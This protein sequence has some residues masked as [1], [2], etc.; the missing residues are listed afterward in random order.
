MRLHYVLIAQFEAVSTASLRGAA[1]FALVE[2]FLREVPN[3]RVR[4]N[5]CFSFCGKQTIW[6]PRDNSDH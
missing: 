5:L 2:A 6:H 1:L 4:Y 3:I